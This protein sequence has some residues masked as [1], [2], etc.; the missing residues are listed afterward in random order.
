M[1]SSEGKDY[2]LTVDPP[3][4]MAEVT[5][6]SGN[7][8]AVAKG[9]G[10]CRFQLPGGIYMVRIRSGES[11]IEEGP[12][13][14]NADQTIRPDWSPMTTG[15]APTERSANH[16]EYQMV[17]AEQISRSPIAFGSGAGL[18]LFVRRSE[19]D[20]DWETP[21]ISV[22]DRRGREIASLDSPHAV[23]NPQAQYSALS[24]LLDPGYYRIHSEAD[25][26]TEMGVWLPKPSSTE[27]QTQVFI[28]DSPERPGFALGE[29]SMLMS[30]LTLGF[31]ASSPEAMLAEQARQALLDGQRRMH[32][33]FVKSV[34]WGKGN[35]PLLGIA[36]LIML[37]RQSERQQDSID[38]ILRNTTELLGEDMPDVQVL[39]AFGTNIPISQ[40]RLKFP[41]IFAGVSRHLPEA[42]E[43]RVALIERQGLFAKAAPWMV[44]T[45]LWTVWRKKFEDDQSTANSIDSR[46]R[47]MAKEIARNPSD[48]GQNLFFVNASSESTEADVAF[49]L[50]NTPEIPRDLRD[51]YRESADH[52]RFP[53][54]TKESAP[55]LAALK[56]DPDVQEL[57]LVGGNVTDAELRHLER[58]TGLKYLWL[59]DTMI[60]DNGLQYLEKLKS[61]TFLSLD[62][63]SVSDAGLIYLQGLTALRLLK[64][65]STQV[66]DDGLTYLKRMTGLKFL[67]LDNTRVTDAGL[68]HLRGL[69]ALRLLKLDNTRVSDAGLIHLEGLKALRHL[70]LESTQVT[71]AGLTYLKRMTG[72]RVLS[73]DNTRVTDAGLIHLQELTGL[74]A[75]GLKNSQVTEAGQE[76]LLRSISG[77]RI[78][79]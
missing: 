75:L 45:R 15:D 4:I 79:P 41:P 68:I 34:A 1:S 54:P 51:L 11:M 12:L 48:A 55:I 37:L 56:E 53:Q 26:A 16:H 10:F 36:A 23:T 18:L 76:E 44:P 30:P 2:T 62:N 24:L 63:T 61:L 70:K 77:L 32:D 71:D 31:V 72:L 14:L 27:W 9:A 38:A 8:E 59:D 5:I 46:V 3:N 6:I 28:T 42:N 64:L 78:A 60:T 7:L 43:S 66:T 40:D 21:S 57:K 65:E 35:N 49:A 25:P 69:T 73:L 74:L 50:A 58:F 33:D 47:A 67:S 17:P 39:R 22:R 29:C 52:F 20:Q 13:L 19:G